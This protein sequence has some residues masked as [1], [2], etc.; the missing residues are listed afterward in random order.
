MNKETE[1]WSMSFYKYETF[2]EDFCSVSFDDNNTYNKI[3]NSKP[4]ITL[5]ELYKFKERKFDISC[6]YKA[7]KY[8]SPEFMGL[9][10]IISTYKLYLQDYKNFYN[11]NYSVSRK[12][13]LLLKDWD[14]K[15][16]DIEKVLT[17][18]D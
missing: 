18:N 15:I 9:D 13:Y 2:L 5:F 8:K 3:K 6:Y 17:K 12:V 10:S 14:P 16:E 4:I 11:R 7:F 1:D